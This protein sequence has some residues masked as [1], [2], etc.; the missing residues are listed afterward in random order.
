VLRVIVAELHP[1]GRTRKLRPDVV[2][3]D[4]LRDT[5]PVAGE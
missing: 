5:A 1:A 2:I 4:G 3:D